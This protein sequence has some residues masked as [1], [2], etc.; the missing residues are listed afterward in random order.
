M[1]WAFHRPHTENKETIE[2]LITQYELRIK[3]KDEMI[4]LLQS[5]SKQKL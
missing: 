2:K 5:I 3:E 4:S 1:N